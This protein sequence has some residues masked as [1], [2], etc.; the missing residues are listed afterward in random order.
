MVERTL[1][2]NEESSRLPG[3]N[4]TEFIRDLQGM[5]P[6]KSVADPDW[7][8][9]V[10]A[11]GD[12]DANTGLSAG[13]A[14]ATIQAAIDRL[15]FTR[16]EKIT[17]HL[18]AGSYDGFY[19]GD[20][21]VDYSVRS[22]ALFAN[23]TIQGAMSLGTLT[24]GVNTGTASAGSLDSED[25][26]VLTKPAAA[27]NWTADD[28][29]GRQFRKVSGAGPSFGYILDNDTT[30]FTLADKNGYSDTAAAFDN[31]TVFE[32]YDHLS[33]IT[34]GNSEVDATDY[35]I[36]VYNTV[37]N[38]EF[39]DMGID[40]DE[41]DSP[42]TV[43]IENATRVTFDRCKFYG[44]SGG[45]YYAAIEGHFVDHLVL[46]ESEFYHCVYGIDLD[47]S[48]INMLNCSMFGSAQ[49]TCLALSNIT[50]RSLIQ[51]SYLD[52]GSSADDGLVISGNLKVSYVAIRDFGRDGVA[53]YGE[54][55]DLVLYKTHVADCAAK[56]IDLTSNVAMA[57]MG[58]HANYVVVDDC[59]AEGISLRS[60]YAHLQNVSGTGNTTYGLRLGKNVNAITSGAITVTGSSGD[61]IIGAYV[62][63]AAT[64][65]AAADD[66][67]VDLAISSG[68]VRE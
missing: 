23:L 68:I 59:G 34:K 50:P 33:F 55:L 8:I 53:T 41:A 7:N 60:C 4:E 21:S 17:I 42:T 47:A 44:N 43:Y 32:I 22:P 49:D 65:L 28:L 19:I 63:T 13:S 15:P 67:V 46:T 35:Y 11:T 18:G 57:G 12:D 54:A 20:A 51:Y 31:T 1:S 30:T 62:G 58:L 52:G 48:E 40:P 14:F 45:D 16:N 5:G 25:R 36:N 38:I 9:Y 56:G 24:S 3:P 39:K 26:Y 66:S 6:R 37:G 61:F 2:D 64:D 29:I 10:G 27:A